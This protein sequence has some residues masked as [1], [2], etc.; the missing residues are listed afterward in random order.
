MCVNLFLCIFIMILSNTP[1]HKNVMLLMVMFLNGNL[2]L[3]S[4]VCAFPI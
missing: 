1:A 2:C 3:V 4:N